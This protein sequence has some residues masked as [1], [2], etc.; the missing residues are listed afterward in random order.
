MN[1]VKGV[2]GGHK[3]T[4]IFTPELFKKIEPRIRKNRK[5]TNIPADN[6]LLKERKIFF[7]TL[8]RDS[9]ISTMI[10]MFA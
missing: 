9:D 1:T 2:Q 10:G 5:P 7:E 8:K 6:K 4:E 3:R